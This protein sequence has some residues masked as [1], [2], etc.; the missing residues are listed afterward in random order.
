[1]SIENTQVYAQFDS[2]DGSLTFFRDLPNKYTNGETSGTKTYYTGIETVNYASIS[3]V[4]WYSNRASVTSV[5]FEN[6]IAPISTACWFYGMNN[7]SF[8]SITSLDKLDTSNVTSMHSIFFGCSSITSL[9]L[10]NFNTSNVTDM[11]DMFGNCNSLTSFDVSNFNTNNVTNMSGMFRNCFTLTNLDL[12]N[13]N[14]SNVADMRYMFYNCNK[15]TSL[16][17][18]SFNTGNVIIM[19]AMFSSCSVLTTLYVS[20]SWDVSGVTSSTN[21]FQDCTNLVGGNGTT[22]NSSYTDKTRAVIDASGTPGYLTYKAATGG[23]V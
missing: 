10:S 6:E 13:F 22:Y 16:N 5:T 11:S 8:T 2:S 21:M 19:S 3:D 12:S 15:L 20:D 1:M 9:D 14:T 17:L 23:A 4:P 18:S 7:V